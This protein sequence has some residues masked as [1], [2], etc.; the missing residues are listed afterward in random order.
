MEQI[1][2]LPIKDL[3]PYKG[4]PRKNSE[5]V[6]AVAASIKE[7]GFKVPIVIDKNN[8]IVN[9]HTRY[10][11]SKKLGLKEVPCIKAE[12]LT[13]EQIKQFRLIDNKTSELSDW[14]PDLLAEELLGMDFEDLDYDFDFTGDLKKRKKWANEKVMCDLKDQLALRKCNDVAYHAL[15]KTGKKGKPLEEIKTIENVQ[16]FAE[17]AKDFLIASLGENLSETDWCI[18]TTPRRR[19]REGFH[20]STEDRKSVV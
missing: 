10:K 6:D 16:F 12:D 1:V 2:Y 19:H 15:F 14:D 11:A 18:V 7:F 9:G 13:E 17:T 3:K 20:F 5:A 8:E 4:N